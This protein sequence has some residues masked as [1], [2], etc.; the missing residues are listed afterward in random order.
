[1]D[2]LVFPFIIVV[3]LGIAIVS[4]S[5]RE[6]RMSGMVENWAR[7]GGYQLISC[8][9]PWFSSGP[10]WFKSKS[11]RIYKVLVIDQAGHRRCA[12]LRCS[13]MF[14]STNVDVEWE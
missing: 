4:A 3:I 9:Q 12:W 11:Q 8:E 7:E 1:M 2:A 14:W 5:A 13:G 10:Y 6:N